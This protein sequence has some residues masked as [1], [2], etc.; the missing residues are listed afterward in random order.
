MPCS[1]VLHTEITT[2]AV[3]LERAIMSFRVQRLILLHPAFYLRLK[4]L[5]FIPYNPK[6]FKRCLDIFCCCF[7][8]YLCFPRTV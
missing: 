2:L 1:S 4:T 8:F 3:V 6:N 7:F 5:L